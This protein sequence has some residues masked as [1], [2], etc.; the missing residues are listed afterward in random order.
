MFEDEDKAI[1]DD[2]PQSMA[3]YNYDPATGRRGPAAGLNEGATLA[4]EASQSFLGKGKFFDGNVTWNRSLPEALDAG[5]KETIE[6]YGLDKETG[7]APKPKDKP[8]LGTPDDTSDDLP[9]P[10]SAGAEGPKPRAK[11]DT[12]IPVEDEPEAV[13]NPEE[14]AVEGSATATNDEAPTEEA[15]PEDVG[16]DPDANMRKFAQDRGMTPEEWDEVSSAVDPEGR[17][18]DDVRMVAA[19]NATYEY[20]VSKGQLKEAKV[21]AM[22]ILLY[23]RDMASR[24]GSAAVEAMRLG[25]PSKAGDYLREAY[26]WVPDGRDV[27]FEL[28]ENGSGRYVQKDAEG[29]VTAEG[30]FSSQEMVAAALGLADGQAYWSMIADVAGQSVNRSG[31][32]GGTS[33]SKSKPRSGGVNPPPPGS[34]AEEA[35]LTGTETP[36]TGKKGSL[37]WK[38]APEGAAEREQQRVGALQ[39]QAVELGIDDQGGTTR[40]GMQS[41]RAAEEEARRA[42]AARADDISYGPNQAR[43]EIEWKRAQRTNDVKPASQDD[44]NARMAGDGGEGTWAGAID[45]Y[46]NQALDTGNGIDPDSVRKLSPVQKQQIGRMAE[47]VLQANPGMDMGTITALTDAAMFNPKAV[48]RPRD[49]FL[50]VNGQ[51]IRVSPETLKQIATAR[52]QL[53]IAGQ[54]RAKQEQAAQATQSAQQR[55]A[56]G[57]YPG[58]GTEVNGPDTRSWGQ[59]IREFVTDG[60]PIYDLTPGGGESA[61]PEDGGSMT[62]NPMDTKPTPAG[63]PRTERGTSRSA[64]QMA[65]GQNSMARSQERAAQA[66]ERP[67]PATKPSKPAPAGEPRTERGTSQ[68]NTQMREGQ[69]SMERSRQRMAEATR[70]PEGPR[71]PNWLES[72]ESKRSDLEAKKADLK[73]Q[74]AAARKSGNKGKMRGLQQQLKAVQA[75]IDRQGTLQGIGEARW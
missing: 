54:Q 35:I 8:V 33:A 48:I 56:S 25:D 75:Q 38:D 5:M 50:E 37:N 27:E 64:V 13:D 65:E 42:H 12:A 61:I 15:I 18:D 9:P 10:P 20:F 46:S 40:T 66:A 51:R 62:V 29:N 16:F 14:E 60:T 39:Q 73:K 63:E 21:A 11:P 1:P 71:E 49:G 4:P 57:S 22:R 3:G 23:G 70:G 47:Q 28:D 7:D 58:A 26:K 59:S 55:R 34:D 52:A 41:E 17:M 19:L 2:E 24:Y 44:I 30:P 53:R 36:E 67:A 43:A 74:L 72:R 68:S 31:G 6:T 45:E 32:G 69:N